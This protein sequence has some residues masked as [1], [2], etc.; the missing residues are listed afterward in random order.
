[1]KAFDPVV[2]R[3]FVPRD[4]SSVD[5]D[6]PTQV[7]PRPDATPRRRPTAERLFIVERLQGRQAQSAPAFQ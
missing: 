4:E 2:A 7:D 1:M 3:G 6:E 5:P